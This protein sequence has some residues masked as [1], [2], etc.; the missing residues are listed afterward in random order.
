MGSTVLN[1]LKT[2]MLLSVLTGLMLFAG[3][4]M[5]G[6]AGLVIALVFAIATNAF[7]YF[8][9]AKI[10]LASMGAQEVGPGDE[11]YEIVAKL[12]QRTGM[13]MPKVYISP[14]EAPNAFAT[15]R[16]PNNAA[17]CATVGLMRTLNRNE[18]A[19]V[20][21][22]EL[23]HVKHRDILIQTVAATIGGAISFLGN[24][25]MWNSMF[26]GSDDEE[27][28][29]P[30]GAIGAILL[31]ILGPIAAAVIQMAVSRQRE[32]AA[33]TEG[34]RICGDP[35]YL[36]TALEKIHV[37]A[38][39]IPMQV[40]PAYNAMMIAEPMGFGERMASLFSTHPRLED[41]LMNLIGR[42]TTGMR[43]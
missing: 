31:M 40:N 1:N 30:L 33:D 18:I 5:G 29:N 22:H 4:A 26:G 11:L 12:V 24:M 19:G 41:R 23:A 34:A 8:F 27:S 28:D 20:M 13:P 37:M 14:Q 35:M 38:H 6:Q 17:V 32:Y 9:S 2:V 21:A 7:G 16:G 25:F 36:A 15:G 3:Y 10:A 39:R 42:E 43:F